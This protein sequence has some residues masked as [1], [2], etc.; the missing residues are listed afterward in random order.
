MQTQ[1][2]QAVGSETPAPSEDPFE[3][4]AEDTFGADEEEE[5]AEAPEAEAEDDIEDEEEADDLPPIDPRYRGMRT[6]KR[7]SPS[8]RAMCRNMCRSARVTANGSFKPSPRR[9]QEPVR[10]PNRLHTSSLPL[11]NGKSLSTSSN[12]P[13]SSM[14]AKPDMALC[15]RPTRV[16]YAYQARQYQ[17]AQ[18]QRSQAQQRPSNTPSR[19]SS[20][21]LTP[22]RSTWPS[23]IRSSSS[24]SRNTPIPRRDRSSSKSCRQSPGSWGIRQS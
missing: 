3:A 18:A 11:T 13:S 1:P 4:I 21:T 24:I 23:S 5:P 19:H 15:W 20:G 10:K 22:S 6:R 2:E 14:V 8:S 17:D 16:T 9:P 12:T 7:S